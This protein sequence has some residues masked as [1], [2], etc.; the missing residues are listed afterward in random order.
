MLL[1]SPLYLLFLYLSPTSC[2]LAPLVDGFSSPWGGT[3]A[4]DGSLVFAEGH[5]IRRVSFPGG[6]VTLI[7]G[8]GN[9][10][11]VDGWGAG[12]ATS[13]GLSQAPTGVAGSN[14]RGSFFVQEV[15]AVRA[16]TP[17]NSSISPFFSTP[18]FP[19]NGLLAFDDSPAGA[20]LASA[21]VSGPL[22]GVRA[23]FVFANGTALFRAYGNGTLLQLAGRGGGG[24][25]VDGAGVPGA[26]FSAVAALGV[27][28]DGSVWVV[29]ASGS[30]RVCAPDASGRFCTV[31][32]VNASTGLAPLGGAQIVAVAGGLLYVAD[33]RNHKLCSVNT[34]APVAMTLAGVNGTL[35]LL[36]GPAAMA[37]FN[38]PTGLA[39]DS[40]AAP[41][42]LF[43]ADGGNHAVRAVAL[44]GGGGGWVTTLAGT[45]SAGFVDGAGPRAAFFRPAQLAFDAP[46]SVLAVAE[47]GNYAVRL[48]AVATGVV[49]TVTGAGT[50]VLPNSLYGGGTVGSVSGPV[51]SFNSPRGVAADPATGTLYVADTG[52]RAL[53]KIVAGWVSTVT[54]LSTATVMFDS[55]GRS[56]MMYPP[57]SNNPQT[58]A[59]PVLRL[60]VEPRSGFLVAA[61]YTWCCDGR[62]LLLSPNAS[63]PPALIAGSVPRQPSRDGVGAG[64]SFLAPLALAFDG[65]RGVGYVA[66]GR[67]V[68]L[69]AADPS[70]SHRLRA[71]F[72][73]GTV[74]TLAGNGGAGWAD[75]FGTSATF[76]FL[77]YAGLA[78][79]PTTGLLL[80]AD[81]PRLRVVNPRTGNVTTVS[82]SSVST[83]A[84]NAPLAS[85]L[86]SN[87][88]ALA[89]DPFSL[90]F[91]LLDA[92]G[93]GGFVRA[94][95]L[96]LGGDGTVFG[97]NVAL[98]AGKLGASNTDGVGTSAGFNLPTSVAADGR[99]RAFIAGNGVVRALNLVTLEVTSLA[100][101]PSAPGFYDGV[102]TSARFA[103]TSP[104]GDLAYHAGLGL[105]LY[106]DAGNRAVRA[107]DP[108]SGAVT[109]LFTSPPTFGTPSGV[110]WDSITGSVLVADAGFQRL[111]RVFVANNTV[112]TLAGSG[113]PAVAAPGAPFPP[114][115]RRP[116]GGV[117]SGFAAPYG[118]AVAMSGAVVVVAN[119]AT[120]T[121]SL[122]TPATGVVSY[123]AGTKGPFSADGVGSAAVL[124]GIGQLTPSA[125]WPDIVYLTEMNQ[126]RVR[127]VNITSRGVITVCGSTGTSTNLFADG[128]V[129]LARLARPEGIAAVPLSAAAPPNPLLGEVLYVTETA[130]PSFR[131]RACYLN[132]TVATVAGSATS[133]SI[134]GALASSTFSKA[135]GVSALNASIMY[136]ADS[137]V[138]KIRLI[139]FTNGSVATAAGTGA[140]GVANGAALSATFNTPRSV[141]A[142]KATGAV[143]IIDQN[144]QRVRMLLG[145]VVTTAAGG[146]VPDA[147]GGV[148]SFSS[149]Q[150][151]SLD[152]SANVLYITDNCASFS[153]PP[154]N[155]LRAMDLATRRV[156]TLAGTGV[157]GTGYDGGAGLAP[158][159]NA[160]ASVA[161]ATDGSG[162]LLVADAGLH[163]VQVLLPAVVSGGYSVSTL[164][165]NGSAGAAVG[166]SGGTPAACA[167]ALPW[168]AVSGP[169]GAAGDPCGYVYVVDSG[170]N[171]VLRVA[172]LGGRVDVVEGNGTFAS[173]GDG[174][175]TPPADRSLAAPRLF[176]PSTVDAGGNATFAY[177]VDGGGNRVR[178]A[179]P[180]CGPRSCAV[181]G[182]LLGNGT[183]ASSDADCAAAN[184]TINGPMS[185]VAFSKSVHS[186]YA[187]A[188][189][190]GPPAAT[191]PAAPQVVLA[192]DRYGGRVR[193]MWPNGSASTLFG[194]AVGEVAGI[195]VDPT[196]ATLFFASRTG[197]QVQKRPLSG[198]G[199][200]LTAGTGGIGSSDGVSSAAQFNNPAGVA[201][202]AGGMLYVADQTNH[203][204]R[205]AS[206]GA[207][208]VSTLA[209]AGTAGW[210]DGVGG[211]ALFNVP[212]AVAVSPAA[213][214]LVVADQFN[215]AIRA[216]ALP[217]G[218]VSTLLRSPGGACGFV[219]GAVGGLPAPAL[220]FP[221]GVAV[222]A[223][224]TVFLAD[225]NNHAIRALTADGALR[226]LVGAG[227]SAPGFADGPGAFARLRSPR[228][229]ALAAD[230][231]GALLVADSDNH[232]MR[233][234]VC[235]PGVVA[236]E[237]AVAPTLPAATATA[238]PTLAA[239]I[240]N[241][242]VSTFAGNGTPC[243]ADGAPG[244]LN[245]PWG[246]AV[247]ASGTVFVV[248]QNNKRVR[249][250]SP[251]GAL[252]TLSGEGIPSSCDNHATWSN[253]TGAAV[254]PATGMLL[255][256]DFNCQNVR[257]LLP[258]RSAHPVFGATI[259][260][261]PV[262]PSGVTV[263]GDGVI[264]VA[265]R[266]THRVL[267]LTLTGYGMF[268]GLTASLG[269]A[270][271]VGSNARFNSPTSVALDPLGNLVVADTGNNRVRLIHP[272]T[273]RVFTLAGSG[274]G[275]FLDGP[276]TSAR[277]R[278]PQGA[279]CFSSLGSAV[280][281]ADTSNHA[282]RH[283]SPLGY[284]STLA[285][286]SGAAGYLDGPG[287]TALLS[288]PRGL[289]FRADGTLLFS[290]SGNYVRLL[291]GG[292]LPLAA[293]PPPPPPPFPN[294]VLP[295]GC[296][297]NVST[298]A[299]T[300]TV[301][302]FTNGATGA[303]SSFNSPFGIAVDPA[304]GSLWVVDQY[305]SRLRRVALNGSGATT[306]VVGSVSGTSDGYGASGLFSN[307]T[308]MALDPA[309]G[310]PP[311]LY[312]ADAPP[313]RRVRRVSPSGLLS[314]YAG[315]ATDFA[316]GGAAQV[317]A[318]MMV[319]I[320]VAFALGKANSSSAGALFVA[321]RDSHA[322]LLVSGRG[323]AGV[324]A[325]RP[326]VAG[327]LDGVGSA[328]LLCSPSAL[329]AGPNGTAFFADTGN[330]AVRSVTL[331][332]VV[333][334]LCGTQGAP[335]FD[336]GPCLGGAH[337]DAPQG[338]AY[339]ANSTAVFVGD[340][341]NNAVRMIYRGWL[342]TVAG[343]PG[344]AFAN[345]LGALAAFKAPRHVAVGAN[346]TLYVSDSG[347][348]AVRVVSCAASATPTASASPSPTPSASPGACPAGFFCAPSNSAPQPCSCPAACPAGAA[349][350]DPPPDSLVW[351][352]STVA[353]S[354]TAG[355][356]NGWGT[357]AQLTQTNGVFIDARESGSIFVSDYGSHMVRVLNTSGFLGRVAGQ[358]TLGFLDANNASSRFYWP[359]GGTVTPYGLVI[360]DS[361]NN[362]L[363]LITT[364]GSS[365][366]ASVRLDAAGVIV[367]SSTVT[368]G[369]NGT[370]SN[371]NGPL[372]IATFATPMGLAYDY[373]SGRLYVSTSS[374][375]GE[376][377][378]VVSSLVTSPTV[379]NLAGNGTAGCV[380]GVGTSATFN[381]AFSLAL[382]VGGQLLYVADRFCNKVR[383]VNTSS[384]AVGTLSGSGAAGSADGVGTAA[385]HHGPIAIAAASSGLLLA[386]NDFS[387]N[388]VRLVST[389][390]GAVLTIAGT[391]ATG[392]VGDNGVGT[393]AKVWSPVG[394]V[395]DFP[396][397]RLVFSDSGNKRLRAITCALP[398]PTP[399]A[400][401]TILPSA[402]VG[403]SPS[404]TPSASPTGTLSGTRSPTP[405]NS[406]TG[407]GAG[408]GTPSG[409]PSGTPSDSPSG[410]PTP[411]GSVT[412]SGSQSPTAPPSPT[413]SP[414]VTPSVT[415]TGAETVSPGAS[416]S[417][418]PS[419]SGNGSSTSASETPSATPTLSPTESPTGSPTNAL[420]STESSTATGSAAASATSVATATSTQTSTQSAAGTATATHS[421][422]FGASGA[423][424]DSG[425][426]SGTASQSAPQ[427]GAAMQSAPA[428]GAATMTAT[429]TGS[430]A[431]SAS[432]GST[433][434]GTQSAAFA[435]RSF[436]FGASGTSTDSGTASSLPSSAVSATPT[437]SAPATGSGSASPTAS[438]AG[439]A[440]A[441]A[442]LTGAASTTAMQTN[443]ASAPATGAATQTAAASSAAT[444]TASGTTSA[445]PTASLT[446]GASA[447]NSGRGSESVT[448]T[449]TQSPTG[450]GTVTSTPSTTAS[451]NSTTSASPTP[452]LTPGASPSNTGSNSLSGSVTASQTGSGT[453]TETPTG[454][455]T[456]TASIT[457]SSTLSGSSTAS[458]SST[459]P[460]S[461]GASPSNT[462][463]VSLSGSSTASPTGTG[464]PTGSATGSVTRTASITP[465]STQSGSSTTTVSPTSSL[466][467]GVSPSSTGS[468]SFSSSRTASATGTGTPTL[469]STGSGTGTAT[470]TPTSI[471]SG[472]STTSASP[473]PSLTR[474][475]SPSITPSVSLSGSATGSPSASATPTASPTASATGTPSNTPSSTRSASSTVS[476]SPTASLSTGASPSATG[477]V[478][479]SGSA[480]PPPSPSATQTG[481]PTGTSTATG[482]D[483]ASSTL[484]ASSTPTVT[485]TATLSPGASPSATSTISASGSA[486]PTRTPPPTRSPTPSGTGSPTASLS[487]GASPS[488]SAPLSGPAT[489]SGGPTPAATLAPTASPTA[490]PSAAASP[491]ASPTTTLS[492]GAPPPSR[493]PGGATFVGSIAGSTLTVAS[494]ITAGALAVGMPLS[495]PGVAPGTVITADLGSGKYTVSVPQTLAPGSSI[496]AGAPSLTAS[497]AAAGGST[498]VGSIDVAVVGGAAGGG[499]V[500]LLLLIGALGF[501]ARRRR[502]LARKVI[503]ASKA[504]R[505]RGSEKERR[506]AWG[507]NPLLRAKMV[508][509]GGGAPQMGKA[510]PAPP[511]GKP[512]RAA[513][514][515]F[516]ESAT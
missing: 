303:T 91:L 37:L 279:F 213:P 125:L 240:A 235:A 516:A 358:G 70:V 56:A 503:A 147:F 310:S 491:S 418:T 314:T 247:N 481:S 377:V 264:Y 295:S 278:L 270:D 12:G 330:N 6:V 390:T 216:V 501:V 257:R 484:S 472:S 374:G 444:D 253:P 369:G 319:P 98:L 248:D 443:A 366:A 28:A 206:Y 222:D 181:V 313:A 384:G 226:T 328:A 350:S 193:V 423:S 489:P 52:N 260:I 241:A 326:G 63:A 95:A 199:T 269:S 425:T 102:G 487:A 204:I 363:R 388:R 239:S 339:D 233:W 13:A 195:A 48:V 347:N 61:L 54:G 131:V 110:A 128:N 462:G 14:N 129:S 100:G 458:A 150:A 316:R 144:S 107:I 284:V 376:F 209:G 208:T 41:T 230:G 322:L 498:S 437:E 355:N 73:N 171:R 296:A 45:G 351:T 337:L 461:P 312:V 365:S 287:V 442:T 39:V 223:A 485:P 87:P 140:I 40:I 371:V 504:K 459:P 192:G 417:Q 185:V 234:V 477:T 434:T 394:I 406:G 1:V 299:G 59:L 306:T 432:S 200:P 132:G 112:T 331:D 372:A 280:I 502:L 88:V 438:A 368:L 187:A 329:A 297:A 225:R 36:D 92:A 318:A 308:G 403:T 497:P 141:C 243:W 32:T 317:T 22:A 113:A 4:A 495:G 77:T 414:T 133:S 413:Q 151:C 488:A 341:G 24:G 277:F 229:V 436:V 511:P 164:V 139:N 57:W 90:R 446:R 26:R 336:D 42:A 232:A 201:S 507:E 30:L 411:I 46:R 367:G 281:V 179:S 451:G 445:T 80:V 354:G 148:V 440:T 380:D 381:Q 421:F 427:V 15:S 25:E 275:G 361:A 69:N 76:N 145:G 292:A 386:V 468:A 143:Y 34:A 203:K 207:F 78:V 53:R 5:A 453:P 189:L 482:S 75:G 111:R 404:D 245:Y 31:T 236:A 134:D 419:V 16:V 86:Y 393:S 130:S 346:G 82:G 342:T 99:G 474:G 72:V 410:T 475:A 109:T 273:A 356:A 183:A 357:A 162:A 294:G 177:V 464:T 8:S 293:Q 499:S 490:S 500:L 118:V 43:V 258:N 290:D 470:A 97:G 422:V 89:W 448:P 2:W 210:A 83:L 19:A 115:A 378:R 407:S 291:S 271:G 315:A 212:V 84:A 255:V 228:G 510:P 441:T 249:A 457:S 333:L 435:M 476:P 272:A 238:P 332:G 433:Q 256:A 288:N 251:E 426:A 401:P 480:S 135:T 10:A 449:P 492:A 349:T 301:A 11:F 58:G 215:N 182:A 286:A 123:L 157:L 334:T 244:C 21:P 496:T 190:G 47:A 402:T 155:L 146:T 359:R 508:R 136:V 515:S 198:A 396:R 250:V 512:P 379:S 261:T 246:I 283:V 486:T 119:T 81:F 170:N 23:S 49:T 180:V 416:L 493:P 473:T 285:G 471:A 263:G 353:G 172:P 370:P 439:S 360:A 307:P 325:G 452:P 108:T 242:M 364:N 282:I 169:Q 176:L 429:A 338:V 352:I 506:V 262:G 220:C 469:T 20:A 455:G 186:A 64:A 163:R 309:S 66:E 259:Q 117:F 478:S 221:T 18:A 465:S 450:S 387:G 324:L 320:A 38:Q 114:D 103:S 254:E 194:G 167:A 298:V 121:L 483:T 154:A 35:G 7:A 9:A 188:L 323:Q 191:G 305:N 304:G 463:S 153:A 158:A 513:F 124:S 79:E 430:D 412:P 227:A 397:S 466:T 138:H 431:A 311:W 50:W 300:P 405:S 178:L 460:L 289:A 428:T 274:V 184:G 96:V 391:G 44:G 159:F 160:P 344:G 266:S 382:G 173:G 149:P 398:S 71:F 33:T 424:T 479:L 335:G 101:A 505:H 219:D 343:A 175:A 17:R 106:A 373:V 94:V 494:V 375:G 362:R 142:H 409:S 399:T 165:G 51:A 156:T 122:F 231:S 174:A 383:F 408:S 74:G 395:F 267:S 415:G 168:T 467:R 3:V 196:G 137:S 197:H 400:S 217:S 55:G 211:A 224:G 27:D 514:R 392:F 104:Y 237:P 105:L 116:L 276:A 166:A 67:G 127:M 385:S 348:H 68:P 456:G 252:S 389:I 509:G 265:H 268:V 93:G 65:A 218:V 60:A 327:F 321:D 120:D 454:T 420:S 214:L 202:D 447:S 340:T 126:N 161:S 62:V 152:A 205:V 302:G 345:G 85:A 29:E